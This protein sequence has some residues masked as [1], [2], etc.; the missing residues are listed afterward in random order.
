MNEKEKEMIKEFLTIFLSNIK[1]STKTDWYVLKK[2][3]I[4]KF[5]D[6]YF[7][8]RTITI[9]DMLN[10]IVTKY[11]DICQ[12]YGI[13]IDSNGDISYNNKYILMRLYQ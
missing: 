2:S 11:K 6:K 9:R 4:E 1:K 13:D 5:L 8:D 12:M 10:N 7:P 3:E